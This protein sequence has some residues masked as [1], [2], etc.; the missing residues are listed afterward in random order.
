M[1]RWGVE[2]EEAVPH[3][4]E[5]TRDSDVEVRTS[6]IEALGRI[7]GDLAKDVLREC[8]KSPDEA[9][10]EA[11]RDALDEIEFWDDPA[12]F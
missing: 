4:L 5:L 8:M 12:S 1:A 3:L 2:A 9:I 11:A 7:G 10:H 6:A